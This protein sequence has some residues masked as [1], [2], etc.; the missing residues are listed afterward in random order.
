MV[1]RTPL[2]PTPWVLTCTGGPA[3]QFWLG[4]GRCWQKIEGGE[5]YEFSSQMSPPP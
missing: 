4:L 3:L 1:H 2:F 5:N